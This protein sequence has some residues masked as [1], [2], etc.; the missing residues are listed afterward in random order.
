MKKAII[1]NILLLTISMVNWSCNDDLQLDFNDPGDFIVVDGW[2]E[3]GAQAKV[4]LTTNSPYFSSIDSASIRDLVLSRAKV[5]L[6]DGEHSEVLILRSDWRYFPPFYYA[7]NT[8]LGESGKVYTLTASFGGKTVVAETTIPPDVKINSS[9]FDLSEGDD[10]I[11]NAVIN[12]TDPPDEKN[13]YRILTRR[14]GKDDKFIPT[15]IIA[16]NDQYFN[17]E[18]ISF[19]FA[20]PPSSVLSTSETE[21]FQ[22]GDTILVKLCT[23]DEASFNFWSSYQDEILNATNPFASSMI[24][25][26]TNIDG[27]GLGI[28]GG[29]G[30][31]IDTIFTNK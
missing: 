14:V 7:G 13:Y 26:R 2:I 19:K 6:S 20:L 11:G 21:F 3:D 12:F 18:E 8:I 4:F 17:G 15:F 25:L 30:V 31:D 10:S 28:W 16:I 22:I 5:T 24:D 27:D 23:M 9:F 29:Y 1:H